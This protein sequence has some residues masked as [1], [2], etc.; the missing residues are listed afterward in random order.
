KIEVSNMEKVRS[1]RQRVQEL[2]D[3]STSWPTMLPK[4]QIK[5]EVCFG[6]INGCI[7]QTYTA[8]N[9]H[10]GKYMCQ[11]AVFYEVRALRYYG[12]V[13]EVSFLA[14][15][16]CDDYGLDTRPV[17]TMIMWLSRC[18]KAGILTEES[19][20]L[21]LSKIGSAEFIETLLHKISFREGFGDILA[22][23]TLKAAE[24]VGKDSKKLITDYMIHTGENEIYGPRLYLTTGLFY[25][26]EPRMPIQQLHEISALAMRWAA[27]EMG[28][29]DNRITTNLTLGTKE[30]Y[31]TSGVLRDIAKR[32]WGSEVAADFSTYEG[33]AMAATKI[34]DRQYVK[35][36]LI[37]CDLSWPIMSSASTCDHVGDP[38]L[39]SQ[40]CT[41]VTGIDVD[42]EGLYQFGERI[43]N[44][45]RAILVREGQKGREHDTIDEFNF[46]ESLRGDVGNPDCIVPGKDGE[47]FSRKGMVVG[48]DEFENMKDEFYALRGWDVSTGLQTKTKLE[49]LDLSDVAQILDRDGLI[50]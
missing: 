27:R 5:K 33:K 14:N 1:L 41:A 9:G 25:A 16:L 29:N 23:G 20:K 40:V 2:R 38:T 15:K 37:L 22:A 44:L 35:E 31:L 11:A 8:E 3:R 19:T 21:P 36:S 49:D 26:M 34:Q 12:K 32:F 24:S 7:R 48:R 45:Q 17:E 13:T 4:D 47:I 39:E 43:F 18:H 28:V 50:V 10:I 6:C 30:N 46:T 42:E